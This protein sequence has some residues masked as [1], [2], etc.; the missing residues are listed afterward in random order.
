M[1]KKPDIPVKLNHKELILL[2]SY[3]QR[4]DGREKGQVLYGI[5]A[6]TPEPTLP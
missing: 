5:L 2:M 1:R 3:R 4:W 6:V